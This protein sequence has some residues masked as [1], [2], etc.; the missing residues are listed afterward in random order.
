[1]YIKFAN[2][3]ELKNAT[4]LPIFM[5]MFSH[6]C[7]VWEDEKITVV[8]SRK[9]ERD[10]TRKRRKGTIQQKRFDFQ[11]NRPIRQRS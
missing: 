11:C 2:K 10:I 9:R 4:T 6:E 7:V 3:I 8:R 5:L 1:M